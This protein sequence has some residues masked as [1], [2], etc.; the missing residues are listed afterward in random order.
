MGCMQEAGDMQVVGGMRLV[1]VIHVVR[2]MQEVGGSLAG[3]R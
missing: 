2:G 3:Y 1:A